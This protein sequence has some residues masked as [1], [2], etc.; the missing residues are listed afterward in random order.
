MGKTHVH[1]ISLAAALVICSVVAAC[2]H[3]V[4]RIEDAFAAVTPGETINQVVNRLGSPDMRETTHLF[5]R[6]AS[7]PC[8]DPCKLRLWWEHPILKGFEAWS[9]EINSKGTVTHKAHFVSP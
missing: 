6:Y 8:V 7:V 3:R 9:V 5:T 1:A 4:S 2:S